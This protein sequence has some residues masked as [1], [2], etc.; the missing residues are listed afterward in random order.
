MKDIDISKINESLRLSGLIAAKAIEAFS[1][2]SRELSNGTLL[3]KLEIYLENER[4]RNDPLQIKKRFIDPVSGFITKRL[5]AI[6]N[7]LDH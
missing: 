2:M 5:I 3:K 4:W 6:A 1:G 7:L